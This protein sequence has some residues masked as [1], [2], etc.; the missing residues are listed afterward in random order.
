MLLLLSRQPGRVTLL[1]QIETRDHLFV[2]R[3]DI[4]ALK[5]MGGDHKG[6]GAN[7]SKRNRGCI[8]R[9]KVE[10]AQATQRGRVEARNI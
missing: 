9:R 3:I 7:P 6:A 2:S 10:I 5:S 8:R 1:K 4:L